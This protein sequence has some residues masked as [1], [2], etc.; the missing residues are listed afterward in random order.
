MISDSNTDINNN[1]SLRPIVF[2]LSVEF[3]LVTG[4]LVIVDFPFGETTRPNRMNNE[5]L[6]GEK[7]FPFI[8]TAT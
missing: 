4:I 6:G 3:S 1:Q 7:G 8:G 5:M 2:L